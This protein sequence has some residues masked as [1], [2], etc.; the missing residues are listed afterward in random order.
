M[1]HV[2][3]FSGIFFFTFRDMGYLGKSILGI[4]A[5]LLKGAI[6]ARLLPG[7]WDIGDPTI[8]ASLIYRMGR[9]AENISSPLMTMQRKVLAKFD[10][11]F[12][13]KTNITHEQ[14]KFH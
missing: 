12:I 6:F 13:P 8:Q 5:Y 11:H 2:V 14:A 7:I 4:F 9:E 1:I 3:V 10:S